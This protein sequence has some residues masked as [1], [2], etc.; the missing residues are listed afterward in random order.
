MTWVMVV[1]LPKG[2]DDFCGIGLIEPFQKAVQIIVSERLGAI[3]LHDSLHGFVV[4][5]GTGTAIIELKLAQQLVHM[6]QELLFATFLD[7]RKAYN[8]LCRGRCLR[9]LQG[10]GVGPHVLE[11]IAY[12]WVNMV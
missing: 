8:V 1:L 12:F 6:E 5:R 2:N 7:L 10:Y 9:I 11:V 3:E 4:E